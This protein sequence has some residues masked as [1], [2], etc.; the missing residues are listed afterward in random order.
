MARYVNGINGPFVGKVGTVV[1]VIREGHFYMRSLPKKRTGAPTAR[2]AAN[3]RKFAQAQ[4]WLQPLKDF[5]RETF[6]GYHTRSQGFI[7]AKSYLLKHA[8][9]GAGEDIIVNPAL[10]KVSIG[11]LPL[12]ANI[13]ATFVDKHA[14]QFTW[15]AADEMSEHATDQVMLLAYDIDKGKAWYKLY[16]QLRKSGAD[17]L[18]LYGYTGKL[19]LYVAF[20]SA[21]RNRR[22]ESVYVGVMEV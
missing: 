18:P 3:R 20:V 12:P 4:L 14:I 19:H 17:E 5:V 11:D 7:A 8:F 15:D 1:G 13:T 22:S 21:D 10:V 6:K 16:G 9:E 2:E